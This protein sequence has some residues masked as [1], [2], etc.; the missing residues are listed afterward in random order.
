MFDIS[1]IAM[2][3]FGLTE[4]YEG[5]TLCEMDEARLVNDQFRVLARESSGCASIVFKEDGDDSEGRMI[6]DTAA[7]KLFL[8]FT[9]R[10]TVRW[11]SNAAG[12]LCNTGRFNME[13]DN[14]AAA[15]TGIDM[16][17]LRVEELKPVPFVPRAQ[18]KSAI[19]FCLTVVMETT[20]S[21]S[22]VIRSVK[23]TISILLRRLETI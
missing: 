1:K 18:P 10:G 9:S 2:I 20:R 6:I 7:S 12:W 4:I 16:K 21:M 23:E 15:K 22:S 5:K 13:R 3:D 8:E 17:G 19:D 11:I 14:N